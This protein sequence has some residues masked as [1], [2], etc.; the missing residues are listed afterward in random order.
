MRTALALATILITS[1]NQSKGSGGEPTYKPKAGETDLKLT[2]EDRG[3]VWIKL[4]KT[5]APKT[6]EHIAKLAKDGFYNDLRFHRVDKVPKPYLVQVGDPHSKKGNLD[7]LGADEEGSGTKIPYEDSGH[8][9]ILGAVGL[10]HSVQDQNSGDSQFYILLGPSKFLNGHYTVF[11]QVVS[12]MTVVTKI[13]KGDKIKSAT[14]V[15][16]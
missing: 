16:G 7:D 12:G 3:D 11:G 5:E 2:I 14:I 4:F 1:L 8:Q 6:V 13:E 15:T 9:N 10:A